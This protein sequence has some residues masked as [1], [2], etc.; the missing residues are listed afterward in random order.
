MKKDSSKRS[1]AT[2]IPLPSPALA[3]VNGGASW[4]TTNQWANQAWRWWQ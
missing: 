1:Q 3:T 4:S 2:F